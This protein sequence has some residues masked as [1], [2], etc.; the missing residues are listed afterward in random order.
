M[1]DERLNNIHYQVIRN[2]EMGDFWRLPEMMQTLFFLINEMKPFKRRYKPFWVRR[3]YEDELNLLIDLQLVE[4]HSAK[5]KVLIQAE[6]KKG[7]K[8]DRKS[9]DYWQ[10]IVDRSEILK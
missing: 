6:L 2:V 5:L 1:N 9:V 7:I 3:K 8:C 10:S 4:G